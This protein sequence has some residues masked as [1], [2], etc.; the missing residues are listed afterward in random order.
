MLIILKQFGTGIYEGFEETP[1]NEIYE[2]IYFDTNTRDIITVNRTGVTNYEMLPDQLI[3]DDEAGTQYFYDGAGGFYTKSTPADPLYSLY[4]EVQPF[5]TGTAVDVTNAGPYTAGTQVSVLATPNE[6]YE[7]TSWMRN[8][9]VLSTN[10]SYIFTMPAAHTSLR[11]N[12]KQL[13]PPPDPEG[14][15]PEEPE[16]EEP[17]H[18][19][20]PLP[21]N[22]FPLEIRVRGVQIP[23]NT[24]VQKQLTGIFTDAF[25]GEYSYPVDIPLDQKIMIALG[26]P[27]D[28][29]SNADF[30]KPFPA[31]LWAH[32]NRRYYGHLDILKSD[33]SRIRATFLLGSGFFI[34]S[35]KEISLQDCYGDDDVILLNQ[36]KYALGGYDIQFTYTNL[37]VKVNSYERLFLKSQYLTHI[38][39]LEALYDYLLSLPLNLDVRLEYSADLTDE[40]SK[41]IYWD[42]TIVTNTVVV[43][44]E[45]TDRNTGGRGPGRTGTIYFARA[46]KLTSYRFDMGGFNNVDAANRIAFPQIWNKE[47]YEGNNQMFDGV[48]NRYDHSGYLQFG[49][50]M[51]SSFSEAQK[52]EHTLIPFVYLLDIVRKIFDHLKISVTGDFFE[53][54]RVKRILVY[55]NRTLDFL[56]PFIRGSRT[57]ERR[58]AYTMATGDLDPNQEIMGYENTHDFNIRLKNHVPDYSIVEF[59]KGMKNYFGLKYDFNIL[60]NRVEIR[61]IRSIIQDR[62]VID[63]TKKA[64][65]TFIL[66]HGK[67]TGIAFQ[68]KDPD[69]LLKDGNSAGLPVPDFTVTNY[70]AL[71]TLDAEIEQV[72]FVRSLRAYFKL[73]TAQDA[74]PFWKLTAFIQQDDKGETRRSWEVGMVPMVDGFYNNYKMPS[75]EMTVNNPELRIENKDC[76][77]RIMA[78]YGKKNNALG[79]PYSF[80]SCTRYNGAE[81]SVNDQYDLDIR[82][83]DT[84]LYWKDLEAII[85]NSKPYETTLI[86]DNVDLVRLSR[87]RKIQIS[88]IV[89]LIDELEVMNTSKEYAIAK[90]KMYKVKL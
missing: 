38:L 19:T 17:G 24:L 10:P 59:L 87:T 68:Y 6:G 32:G 18:D 46:S 54:D 7:F 86:L 31:Q 37:S 67:E 84:Y 27:N 90:A 82:S 15:E 78:F 30:S 70:L 76:G 79:H 77:I 53:D 80:A 36:P 11:A 42:T 50:L 13:P 62:D 35:N 89:Y 39:M 63:M 83:D 71:D 45:N 29:Q 85:N 48:V 12:F 73:V 65:K 64:S 22:Y 88:N 3:W 1:E 60:N 44:T 20:T 58:T 66:S 43:S 72:A 8:G 40:F 75:I 5:G 34:Q 28:P 23:L 9:L 55:N 26:L 57:A 69:P 56:Q 61:F 52:W 41:I 14:P 4:F 49:N 51:Y 16:P 74:P 21:P 47:L 33:E 25:E 2:T 81:L